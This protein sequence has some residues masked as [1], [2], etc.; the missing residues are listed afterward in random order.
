[1]CQAP[2][3]RSS[4]KG[5]IVCV[6]RT[7][8][9]AGATESARSSA[10]GLSVPPGTL[11]AVNEGKRVEARWR[12]AGHGS[13]TC[14]PPSGD[15]AEDGATIVVSR[16]DALPCQCPVCSRRQRL[17]QIDIE[18]PKPFPVL[19]PLATGCTR[20]HALLGVLRSWAEV[21]NLY[22]AAAEAVRGTDPFTAWDARQA[23]LHARQ[24]ARAA[25]L[26][27]WEGPARRLALRLWSDDPRLA[28]ETTEL[29]VSAV[30]S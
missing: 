23:E 8:P 11:R 18:L 6:V 25:Q 10:S 13:W 7:G 26:A 2:V 1:V 19:G 3:R 28:P 15:L 17:W 9:E 27:G 22:A 16:N 5:R 4:R 29:I 14:A 21:G 12:R 30:L 20:G 24:A